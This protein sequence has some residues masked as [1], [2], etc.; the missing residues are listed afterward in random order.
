MCSAPDPHSL[1]GLITLLDLVDNLYGF[2]H[3]SAALCGLTI[4]R[5]GGSRMGGSR[6]GGGR[7]DM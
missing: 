5:M 7:D 6:N 4:E 3:T 2:W 1:A